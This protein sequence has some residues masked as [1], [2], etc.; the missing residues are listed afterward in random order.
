[1]SHT[2]RAPTLFTG[3]KSRQY[4]VFPGLFYTSDGE[5]LDVPSD[6][7]V[8]RIF[9]STGEGR[10]NTPCAQYAILG[11][12]PDVT[13]SGA[14][15]GHDE[16]FLHPQVGSS[17][18]RFRRFRNGGEPGGTGGS[19]NVVCL[20]GAV[21]AEMSGERRLCYPSHVTS[22]SKPERGSLKWLG[23]SLY[24]A[25]YQLQQWDISPKTHEVLLYHRNT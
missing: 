18:R 13:G 15:S 21:G 1:M 14:R 4:D 16:A 8:T 7:D 3:N 20:R 5:L 10:A 2:F 11:S 23:W 12:N 9:I 19:V 22:P 25:G 24:T 17:G 6:E